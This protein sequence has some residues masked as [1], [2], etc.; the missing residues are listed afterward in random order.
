VTKS[1]RLAGVVGNL[2]LNAMAMLHWPSPKLYQTSGS[3]LLHQS[4]I[5]R[6]PFGQRNSPGQK[7]LPD[8]TADLVSK[9]NWKLGTSSITAMKSQL[10]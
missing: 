9:T 2:G 10:I 6:H 1:S 8:C 4:S 7:F 5:S 3:D